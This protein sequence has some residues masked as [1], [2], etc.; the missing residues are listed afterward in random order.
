MSGRITH[1]LVPTDFSPGS[2]AALAWARDLAQQCAARLSLLHVVTDPRAV[3]FL[4]PEVYVPPAPETQERLLRE[5]RER[6]E[7]ALPADE[8]SRFAVTIDARIGEVAETILETA[9]EQRVD[10]IVMG[11]HGRHGLAHLL[12]GS[13]AE[14][15]LRNASCPV[16]TTHAAPQVQAA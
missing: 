13:V 15:V 12:L 6:L 14:R 16:L 10:L 3:G 8:R 2:D 4:T 11:T 7:R 1:I 9:R 5:A